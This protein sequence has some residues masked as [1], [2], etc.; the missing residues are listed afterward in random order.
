MWHSGRWL[1]S[2][3]HL[4]G[5]RITLKTLGAARAWELRGE[6]KQLPPL[7]ECF[8]RVSVGS[9]YCVG[10]AHLNFQ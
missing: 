6:V 2:L 1:Y 10:F 5:P 8:S 3:G 7:Y 4:M 9:H